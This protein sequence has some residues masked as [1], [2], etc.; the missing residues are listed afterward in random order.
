[1]SNTSKQIC[2][3]AAAI[4]DELNNRLDANYWYV[5]DWHNI[6]HSC[7][8]YYDKVDPSCYFYIGFILNIC[9][10]DG[11]RFYSH[12]VPNYFFDVEFEKRKELD[13]IITD[14]HNPNYIDLCINH[15]NKIISI[16]KICLEKRKIFASQEEHHAMTFERCSETLLW[17]R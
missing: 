10:I 12:M 11:I 3:I 13:Y 6:T 2:I 8:I 1:M 14:I 9:P 17:E 7:E 4:R 5:T 16:N 15:I